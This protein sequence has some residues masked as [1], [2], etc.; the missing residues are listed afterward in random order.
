M[1]VAI[2]VVVV[3]IVVAAV[4]LTAG[5]ALIALKAVAAVALK[6]AAAIKTSALIVSAA[7]KLGVLGVLLGSVWKPLKNHAVKL[8]QSFKK[9]LNDPIGMIRDEI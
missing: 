4:V 2:A 1:A 5:A 9:F 3:V 6:V 8:W 7:K